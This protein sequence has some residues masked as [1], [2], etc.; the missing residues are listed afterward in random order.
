MTLVTERLLISVEAEYR[1][2]SFEHLFAGYSLFVPPPLQAACDSSSLVRA[3]FVFAK[4]YHDRTGVVR[5]NG[6]APYFQ[7]VVNVASL[8]LQYGGT[9]VE[10][11]AA[12]LHDVAED[13]PCQV[14]TIEFFFGEDVA[15]I[16]AGL[17]KLK[18]PA[19]APRHEKVEGWLRQARN[20]GP[21]AAL[22]RY[23][24]ISDNVST[25]LIT[26]TPD[27]AAS[28]LLEKWCWSH[29]ICFEGVSGVYMRVRALIKRE[30]SKAGL[31]L[32]DLNADS[33]FRTVIGA[34]K[35]S[36]RNMM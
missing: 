30:A 29:V 3:A 27:K 19:G 33:S 20:A 36:E 11:A 9:G 35:A 14:S 2:H 16:V 22:V 25:A 8:V 17:T 21:E 4:Y 5:K 26:F 1:R 23:C 18:F 24:D 10:V 6:A 7:H 15:R 12:L 32:P 31:R 28:Y 34:Y 13:T